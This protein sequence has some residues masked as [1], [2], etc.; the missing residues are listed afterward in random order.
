MLK[1]LLT[2]SDTE[3]QID[4]LVTKMTKAMNTV[5]RLLFLYYWKGDQFEEMYGPQKLPEFEG[6]ARKAFEVLGDMILFLKRN[7]LDM[8]AFE[9]SEPIKLSDNEE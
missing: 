5:G 3:T 1:S 9:G 8:A 4:K 6:S 2:N 7:K